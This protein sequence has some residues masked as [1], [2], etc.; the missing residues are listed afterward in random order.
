MAVS[1]MLSKLGEGMMVSLMIFAVTLVFSLPLGL[2]D[3]KSV[4]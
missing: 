1:V 4:V 3:R 2:L